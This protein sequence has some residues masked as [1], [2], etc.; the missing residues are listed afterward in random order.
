MSG[1]RLL[2]A[3]CGILS[4][5]IAW[6]IKK[7]G[8]PLDTAFLDSSLHCDLRKLEAGLKGVLERHKA[9]DTI[10]F[11]GTC[12][13]RMDELLHGARTIRTEG[14]NCVEMLLGREL[15]SRELAAGAFFLLEDWARRWEEISFE[16]FGTRNHNVVREIYQGDRKYLLCLRTPCSADFSADAVKAGGM[17]GLPLRW[18]DVG[19]D[20]LEAVLKAAMDRK[21]KEPCHG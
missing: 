12:H 3:G 11:Y 7:N 19:L 18:L 2:L 5:E 6:L 16:T 9:R 1:E 17:T 20:N 8:W 10:V 13:P 15:F 14:Q 4:K 21:M